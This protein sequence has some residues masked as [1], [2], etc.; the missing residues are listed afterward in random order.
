MVG[1]TRCIVIGI[2]DARG[3]NLT[4]CVFSSHRAALHA[5]YA[6]TEISQRT[7]EIILRTNSAT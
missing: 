2:T 7:E 6:N 5:E 3:D 4:G 1:V